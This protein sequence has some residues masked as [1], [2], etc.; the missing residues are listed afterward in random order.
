MD[1]LAELRAALERLAEFRRR[2]GGPRK[3]KK[4]KAAN[5][6]PAKMGAS[7]GCGTGAGGFKAGNNCATEDGIPQKPL[8]QGGALKQGN[9]KD[10]LARAKAMREKAAAK[11]A[12]KEAA[13]R[14]KSEAARPQREAKA[15]G[16]KIEYLRRKAAERKAQKGERDAA[17]K[18]AAAEAAAKKRA[19]MLQKIRVKKANERLAVVDKPPSVFS[20][21]GDESAVQKQ[22]E[23]KTEFLKRKYQKDLDTYHSEAAKIEARYEKQLSEAKKDQDDAYAAYRTNGSSAML[24][25]YNSAQKRLE[26]LKGQRDSELHDLV[27]E[28]TLAHAGALARTDS[29]ASSASVFV[30]SAVA[31]SRQGAEIAKKEIARAWNWLSRVAAKKHEERI[32]GATIRLRPGGGGSHQAMNG[33]NDITIGVDDS[34]DGIR[35]TTAHEYGHAIETA[36]KD[37]L[38]ALTEDY[39]ARAADFLASNAGAKY[40]AL[41][42]APNYDAIHKAGEKVDDYNIYAPS[43]LGYAR[44]YSDAGF[45]ES[46]VRDYANHPDAARVDKGTEVFSTGIESVYHEPSAFRNRARHG[47]DI[48]LLVLAGLL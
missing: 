19:A 30:Q 45:K 18:Q 11:K 20:G 43:Y 2:G 42:D 31:T 41:R 16:K 47:F 9:A 15:K 23:L 25:K 48:S 5:R 40:K 34:G 27:G 13:D 14:A 1:V 10:D 33:K 29:L 46:M 21:R 7:A 8:S 4:V 37:T 22:G 3:Q 36:N 24:D 35:K 38:R 32:L 39:R 17:E 12:R 6:R 44:R 26:E 28:F